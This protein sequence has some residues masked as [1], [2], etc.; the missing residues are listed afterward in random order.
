MR[1]NTLTIFLAGILLL[2]AGLPVAYLS[3]PAR[4]PEVA[5]TGN[6]RVGGPFELVDHN[7]RTVTD[8]TF[9]GRWTLVFFGFT[10]CPD[11][12][13]TALADVARV[14]QLMEAD[15]AAVQPLF[16]TVD[17]ERD[18]PEILAEYTTFF[19]ERIL[20]LSGTPEQV[21]AATR[22]FNIYVERV[23]VGDTYTLDHTTSLFLM[24]PEGDYVQRFSQQD[25]REGIAEQIRARVS[26]R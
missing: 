4:G 24:N 10:H 19:D 2:L 26:S 25:S 14:M 23:P 9:R 11:A 16:I 20:G 13:P 12:C 5:L 6:D 22:A 3:W 17:P 18:T 21:A 7:D 1:N 15:A 8:E